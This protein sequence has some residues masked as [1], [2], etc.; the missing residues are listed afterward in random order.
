MPGREGS[1]PRCGSSWPDLKQRKQQEQRQREAGSPSRLQNHQPLRWT[2][3]STSGP[4]GS[5]S[6]GHFKQNSS[7]TY[8]SLLSRKPLRKQCFLLCAGKGLFR[9]HVPKSH[10]MLRFPKEKM[11]ITGDVFQSESYFKYSL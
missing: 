1:F 4:T 8:I 11:L 10:M 6:G 3:T 7:P 5:T 2:P 9:V